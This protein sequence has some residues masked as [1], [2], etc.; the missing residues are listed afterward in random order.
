MSKRH[1]S[2][3]RSPHHGSWSVE[4]VVP[5]VF[6]STNFDATVTGA[7]PAIYIAAGDCESSAWEAVLAQLGSPRRANVPV[8]CEW[9]MCLAVEP[10]F[11]E[12]RLADYRE[13]FNGLWAPKFGRRMAVLLYFWHVL[14]QSRLI[15]WLIRA[16]G[17]RL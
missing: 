2:I 17:W 5:K 14:R 12:D 10:E 15:D 8:I 1:W 13:R 3:I 6:I 16:F 7:K 11:Q 9:L 4:H